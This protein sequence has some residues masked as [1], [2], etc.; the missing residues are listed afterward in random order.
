[1]KKTQTGL[2]I[3]KSA[4]RPNWKNFQDAIKKAFDEIAHGVVYGLK[5][6]KDTYSTTG[7]YRDK[8][9]RQALKEILKSEYRKQVSHIFKTVDITMPSVVAT[10]SN[11]NMNIPHHFIAPEGYWRLEYPNYYAVRFYMNE[12]EQ[13]LDT[14]LNQ[15]YAQSLLEIEKAT[16]KVVDEMVDGAASAVTNF[17]DSNNFSSWKW[18]SGNRIWLLMITSVLYAADFAAIGVGAFFAHRGLAA[19]QVNALMGSLPVDLLDTLY[20]KHH[21][22][23]FNYGNT[24]ELLTTT[25]RFN[26]LNDPAI[27]EA[28]KLIIE[29]IRMLRCEFNL[30]EGFGLTG[31]LTASIAAVFIWMIMCADNT[32]SKVKENR[33]QLVA[34][35]LGRFAQDFSI[36]DA[37]FTMASVSTIMTN[38]V[39]DLDKLDEKMKTRTEGE[40]VM[41]SHTTSTT[42]SSVVQDNENDSILHEDNEGPAV[43]NAEIGFNQKLCLL[44]QALL[45]PQDKVQ[46]RATR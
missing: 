6:S 16:D 9:Q 12:T 20:H 41:T 4:T 17:E 43:I 27:N 42:S 5:I 37:N 39:L 28:Q 33:K 10:G 14:Q 3:S 26:V 18:K 32:S 7:I 40:V 11:Q 22:Y 8:N 29:Q 21:Y 13:Q 23:M 34:N 2:I 24:V 25:D 31:A 35:Y 45:A 44:A 46:H 38:S 15:D 19:E 1:M 30:Y 36:V